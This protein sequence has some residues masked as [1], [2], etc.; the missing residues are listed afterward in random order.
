MRKMNIMKKVLALVL[1]LCTAVGMVIPA[2]AA[3]LERCG[4]SHVNVDTNGKYYI[5]QGKNIVAKTKPSG[6]QT[7]FKLQQGSLIKV[8]GSDGQYYKM[9]RYEKVF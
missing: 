3:G 5:T 9:T 4:V 2:Y 6:G 7:D 8:T 1:V